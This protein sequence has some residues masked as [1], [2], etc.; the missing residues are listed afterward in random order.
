MPK[1][2]NATK[3]EALVKLVRCVRNQAASAM[4]KG[5]TIREIDEAVRKG[6]GLS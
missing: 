4:R 5:A 6:L 2:K 1:K 3:G